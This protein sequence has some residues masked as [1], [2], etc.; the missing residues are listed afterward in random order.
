MSL[1]TQKESCIQLDKMK[2]EVYYF[3]FFALSF[4]YRVLYILQ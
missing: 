2:C 3:M 4:D 1:V